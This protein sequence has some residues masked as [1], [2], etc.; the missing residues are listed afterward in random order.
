[1]ANQFYYQIVDNTLYY[2][3]NAWE[4]AKLLTINS[5]TFDLSLSIGMVAKVPLAKAFLRSLQPLLSDKGS[6]SS[7]LNKLEG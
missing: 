4:G 6:F 7:Y 5:G 1:M 2:G 3:A